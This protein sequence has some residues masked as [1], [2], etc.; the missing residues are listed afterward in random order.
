M[1]IIIDILQTRK[2]WLRE[3]KKPAPK[4]TAR[5]SWSWERKLGLCDPEVMSPS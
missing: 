1:A 4:H 5:E 2:W 3:V